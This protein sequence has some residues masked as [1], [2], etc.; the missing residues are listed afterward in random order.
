MVTQPKVS[1]N[2][3]SLRIGVTTSQF[4]NIPGVLMALGIPFRF[5]GNTV[6]PLKAF[7][8]IFIGCT[9][10]ESFNPAQIRA[11]VERGGVLYVSDLSFHIL[12]RAFPEITP[13]WAQDGPSGILNCQVIAPSLATQLGQWIPLN[14]NAQAWAYPMQ[15]GKQAEALISYR[16][17]K[18]MIVVAFTFSFGK[19]K[20]IYTSFHNHAN[21]TQ[22]EKAIL[23]YMV[24]T[25]IKNAKKIQQQRPRVNEERVVQEEKKENSKSRKPQ[26]SIQT[27]K[28]KVEL[29]PRLRRVKPTE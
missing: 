4:D 24:T 27:K 20:V 26:T 13:R 6:N 9:T 18:G 1:Q 11:F 17:P 2:I 25:P 15:L 29:I 7:N 14:F 3:E 12:Q 5:T 22:T 19:G 28:K 23:A 16:A 8:V 10:S 21:T